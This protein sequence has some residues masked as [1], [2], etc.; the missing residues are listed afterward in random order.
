MAIHNAGSMIII[1]MRV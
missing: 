1:L